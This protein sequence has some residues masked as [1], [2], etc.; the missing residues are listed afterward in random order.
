MKIKKRILRGKGRPTAEHGFTLPGVLCRV[1]LAVALVQYYYIVSV[2]G[3][4]EAVFFNSERNLANC[5]L[6]TQSLQLIGM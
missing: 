4:S 3:F 2:F 5:V 6:N 1:A